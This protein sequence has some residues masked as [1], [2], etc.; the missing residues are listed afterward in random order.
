VVYHVPWAESN[1]QLEDLYFSN[2]RPLIWNRNGN[3]SAAQWLAL[4]DQPRV[5][6]SRLRGIPKFS[7]NKGELTRSYEELDRREIRVEKR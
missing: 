1:G 4:I 3:T 6:S 7:K 5:D 2:R